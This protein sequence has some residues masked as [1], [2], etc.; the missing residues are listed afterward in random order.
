MKLFL[1]GGFLGSGKSTSIGKTCINLM[2]KKI[3]AAVITNDQGSN[4]VDTKYFESLGIVNREVL[5]GCFCCNYN[6]LIKSLNSLLEDEK[7]E[8]IFAESVGSCTDLI[9][10][11]AKPLATF[12]PTINVV[13]SVYVDV[14]MLYRII[15]GEASFLNDQ[16][17][18]IYKK[19][20]EEADVLIINKI[21][22]L[23]ESEVQ[24]VR[25]VLYAEYP[26]KA[27]LYQ[28]SFDEQHIEQWWMM[29]NR[30]QSKGQRTSIKLN[31]DIYAQGEAML[32]WLDKELEIYA[33]NGRAFEVAI[34]LIKGIETIIRDEKHFI[35]HLKFLI[36]DDVKK[37][38]I[39]YT[40]FETGEQIFSSNNR[41]VNK[42]SMLI[43]ARVQT[44]P[45][46]LEEIVSKTIEAVSSQTN[47][48]F[49]LKNSSCFQP[50]YPNPTYHLA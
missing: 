40:A 41:K 1:I 27:I 8:I 22:L 13:I 16:V 14:A 45:S 48:Q 20:I 4:L 29:I 43:N 3:K 28:N 35:G 18:Y 24:I 6:E 36:D 50:G 17:R 31:Y 23:E 9:A 11:I 39:S 7:P 15:R 2:K 44:I 47:C 30:Y 49:I 19:Q 38:K 33:A 25:Q 5:N 10:T 37:K 42:V 21:D 26:D 32:G 34:Q 12:Y 46:K